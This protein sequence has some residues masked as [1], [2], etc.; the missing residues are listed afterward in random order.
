MGDNEIILLRRFAKTGDAEAFSQI[1]Q[2]HT[3]MVYGISMRLLEDKHQAADVTQQ[4]FLELIKK[5]D[6][7]TSTLSSWLHK[8]ATHKAIDIIRKDSRRRQREARYS[9]EKPLQTTKWK[10][11][12]FHIDQEL[13]NLD[14]QTRDILIS[15]FFQGRTTTEIAE[16]NGISQP[17]ASRRIET[18]VAQLRA[19]LR[20]KGLLVAAGALGSLLLQNASQAAPAVVMQELGKLAIAGTSAATAS[21]L[22][23]A[24]AAS[25][26]AAKASTGLM[27]GVKAKVIA[28][29]AAAAVGVGGAITYKEVTE[30]PEPAPVKNQIPQTVREPEIKQKPETSAEKSSMPEIQIITAEKPKI[31]NQQPVAET[32]PVEKPAET[33]TEEQRPPPPARVRRG[34]RMPGGYGGYYGGYG[35]RVAGS[36]EEEESEMRED[37]NEPEDRERRGRWGASRQR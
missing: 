17:T 22:G 2:I 11:L 9:A 4:T 5:A 21:S 37:P 6:E 23:G 29:T 35:G 27:V 30:S 15:R 20:K 31:K 25:G 34:R 10:D 16:A 7:I 14:Q 28:V 19:A 18:A 26:T 12:S 13:E 1:L 36:A 8:V 32:T 3:G 24:T 33:G